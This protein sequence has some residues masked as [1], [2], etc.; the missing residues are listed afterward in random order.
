[1][2][3]KAENKRP[4]PN[5]LLTQIEADER[6]KKRGKLKIFFGSSAGVGKTYAMLQEAHRRKSEGLDIVAGLVETHSRA[7]TKQL[8]EGLTQLPL[9]DIDH[10]GVSIKEFDLDAALRRK[11]AILLVDELAHNNAPGCRHPKR[12]QDIEELLAA[13]INVY[14]TLNV[15][16]LESL[17]DVVESITGIPVRE[18]VPDKVFDAADDIIL[19]DTPPDE[20]LHRLKEGKVYIAPGANERA[21]QNFF[22]KTNLLSLR[23]LALRRMADYVDADTNEERQREGIMT[24]NIA[25]DHIMVCIGPDVFAAKLVR[26]AKRMAAALKSPWTAVYIETPDTNAQTQR[27]RQYI[28]HVLQSAERNGAHIQTLQGGRI[29]DEIM[30]YARAKGVTK[31]IIGKSIRSYWRNLLKRRL[32]DFVIEESGDID[33]YVVTTPAALTQKFNSQKTWILPQVK[34]NGYVSSLA[35]AALCTAIGYFSRSFLPNPGD[36]IM[37]YMVGAVTVAAWLG[38]GPAI[39]YS[40]ISPMAL[41]FFFTE[42]LYTFRVHDS[43]YWLTF[44]VM[45]FA[46]FVIS[47]QAAKLREQFLLSR[48]RERESQLFYGLTKELSIARGLKNMNDSFSEA[49]VSAV[50]ADTHIWYPDETGKVK[51]SYGTLT[52]DSLKEETAAQWALD[53]GQPAGLGTDT[54]PSATRYYLPLQ[55]TRAVLGVIGVTPKA[56]DGLLLPDQIVMLETFTGLLASSLERYQT[57]EDAEKTKL[58]VEKEKLRNILLSSVSHDLRSPLSAITGA[59]DTLLQ[60]GSENR[61]LV[62]IRQEAGRLSRII[63]NLLDITRIEG[64]QIKLNLHPYYP[65]EIIGSAAE[66]SRA[67]MKDHILTLHVQENIPFVHMDGMLVSQLIQNLIENAAHHTP[68]GTQV[69]VHANMHNGAFTIVVSDNGPGIP[70]GQEKEIFNKFATFSQGD[71]PKGTGLGLAICQ[72]I[73]TAHHGRIWAENK[74]EGGARFIAEFPAALVLPEEGR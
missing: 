32:I 62:S 59:A 10:R 34:M 46:C 18:M 54:M 74:P 67:V 25:G 6:K 7:E 11:P 49:V 65:P 55:G 15:Q 19:V 33:V 4:D 36:L 69:E 52:E 31:I 73:M 50:Q 71:R 39:L 60:T 35:I 44:L 43:S 13:G 20:L 61:L 30:H 58:L 66:S 70:K 40:V 22:K 14:T 28:Q 27:V 41:N 29:G 1:M 12:W 56:Q 23:E 63:N 47:A 53:H 64:G 45:F 42:P 38:R 21:V 16:H 37:I 9:K 3:V 57:A 5:T 17:N 68:P 72:A 48:R 2:P 8:L 26:T 24:P 51:L